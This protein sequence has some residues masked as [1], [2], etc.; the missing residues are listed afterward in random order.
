LGKAGASDRMEAKATG[1]QALPLSKETV[2]AS[3]ENVTRSTGRRGT[4]Y[5]V[6]TNG[7]DQGFVRAPGGAIGNFDVPGGAIIGPF[8]EGINRHPFGNA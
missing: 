3:G 7:V 5:Y 2:N 4:G 1:Y 6:E 8:P